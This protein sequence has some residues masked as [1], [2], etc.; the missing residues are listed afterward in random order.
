MNIVIT[1]IIVVSAK[2]SRGHVRAYRH[3]VF[4][5]VCII[6]STAR[7]SIFNWRIFQITRVILYSVLPSTSVVMNN[8]IHRVILQIINVGCVCR[9]PY[10]STLVNV[11]LTSG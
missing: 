5:L 2:I 9:L 10:N 3:S 1:I 8:I 7:V 11:I 4:R 6:L